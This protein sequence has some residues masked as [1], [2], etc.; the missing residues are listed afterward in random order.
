MESILQSL[1][2]IITSGYEGI[3]REITHSL[4]GLINSITKPLWSIVETVKNVA[5]A[6]ARTIADYVY[7]TISLIMHTLSS[8][9]GTLTKVIGNVGSFVWSGLQWVGGRIWDG[10][11]WLGQQF[12]GFIQ[13]VWNGLQW[14]GQQIYSGLRFVWEIISIIPKAVWNMAQH[15]GSMIWNSLKGFWSW[16]WSGINW[17]WRQIT[18]FFSWILQQFVQFITPFI[19]PIVEFVEYLYEGLKYMQ[20][21]IQWFVEQAL[22]FIGNPLGY[23]WQHIIV[24]MM[25]YI[26][27]YFRLFLST[28]G[29]ILKPVS[30]FVMGI[31]SSLVGLLI[32]FAAAT[33]FTIRPDHNASMWLLNMIRGAVEYAPPASP[34]KAWSAAANYLSIVLGIATSQFAWT[35]AEKLVNMVASA[36]ILGTGLGG[37]G[38]G[39]GGEFSSLFR[40]ISFG[41]G[42]NWLTW[43]IFGQMFRAVIADPLE[44]YYREKYRTTY[45]TRTMPEEWLRRGFINEA[46]FLNE[47]RKLGY[48]EEYINLILRAAYREVS[49]SMYLDMR[50]YGLI[51]DADLMN[52][53]NNLGY[54]PEVRGLIVEYARLRVLDARIR[55]LR[56]RMA[57]AYVQGYYP[58]DDVTNMLVGLGFPSEYV[59][60]FIS[61]YD[62]DHDIEVR[63]LL[64]KT[65]F[66]AYEKGM[67]NEDELRNRLAG[68]ITDPH[69]LELKILYAKLKKMPRERLP[70]VQTLHEREKEL[71]VKY[72]S[73]QSQISYLMARR[74]ENAD[75]WNAR[76]AYEKTKYTSE[77]Q[78][79]KDTA[80]ADI[81]R[82][83]RRTDI[84]IKTLEEIC[85]AYINRR[86]EELEARIKQLQTR[87]EV[88]QSEYSRKLEAASEEERDKILAEYEEKKELLESQIQLLIDMTRVRVEERKTVCSAR[89]NKYRELA[90]ADIQRIKSKADAKIKQ[91]Q[92]EME[93]RLKLLN[94]QYEKED[95]YFAER[96]N[97]LQGYAEET[98]T[99]LDIV[100]DLLSRSAVR[101]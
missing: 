58:R 76:I 66:E 34:T 24:P 4:A 21:L 61:S 60:A 55:R 7:G 3:V 44:R 90:E 25:P 31:I 93:S 72:A 50:E 77:I 74:K 81:E 80:E 39:G 64:E 75:Y 1:A 62:V 97:K 20:P 33:I 49:L 15:I 67:I 41:L 37:L 69:I 14:L 68:V 19:S 83:K 36:K 92:K 2:H 32:M 71:S 89:I 84:I 29:E 78:K 52:A 8:L 65:M 57:Y 101:M 54:P 98:K 53:V 16:I 17:V 35:M 48:P 79:I 11:K 85:N 22:L 82:I 63:E 13:W 100:R 86:I 51:S 23:I 73:L 47:M 42:L 28:M 40:S 46:T 27:Q 5:V 30:N 94:E 87:L 10:L 59:Q 9:W 95:A 38:G 88:L 70:N 99:E 18:G 91:L 96:I 12:S 26:Q 45:P 56:E 43:I 6:V